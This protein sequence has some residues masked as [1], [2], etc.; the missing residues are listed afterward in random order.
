MAGTPSNPATP[1]VCDLIGAYDG[2]TGLMN[3][4]RGFDE[5]GNIWFDR[6]TPNT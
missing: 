4:F 2:E 5:A 1:K 3:R 6:D